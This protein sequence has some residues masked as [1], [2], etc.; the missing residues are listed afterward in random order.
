MEQIKMINRV[1]RRFCVETENNSCFV[2]I[3]DECS[4]FDDFSDYIFH[5]TG[6]ASYRI[7]KKIFETM[8]NHRCVPAKRLLNCHKTPVVAADGR[9]AQIMQLSLL[10]SG[11]DAEYLDI[12]Q[13]SDEQLTHYLEEFLTDRFILDA[14]GTD[15]LYNC[16]RR[17]TFEPDEYIALYKSSPNG[18]SWYNEKNSY[19]PVIMLWGELTAGIR[20]YMEEELGS[21]FQFVQNRI[22]SS[23]LSVC[24]RGSGNISMLNELIDLPDLKKNIR[25]EIYG[26]STEYIVID[27]LNIVKFDCF[28]QLGDTIYTVQSQFKESVWFKNFCR[29]HPDKLIGRNKIEWKSCCDELIYQLKRQ[30]GEKYV[31][32]IGIRIDNDE[33]QEYLT[34]VENYVA[35]KLQCCYLEKC[36]TVHDSMDENCV[37]NE[38]ECRL[39]VAELKNLIR[40]NE[41]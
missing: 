41:A 23:I 21:R 31:L 10:C 1:M 18:N 39:V 28:V 14:S 2:N 34:D 19:F 11:I 15:R 16:I 29:E 36:L 13:M 7:A 32:L 20:Q 25:R 3:N 38:R 17:I 22:N 12:E 35:D 9:F 37:L 27:F 33:L 40:T 26:P 4:S 30:Y 8:L 6:R 5:W 24:Q